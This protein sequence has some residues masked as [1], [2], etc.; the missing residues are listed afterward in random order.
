MPTNKIRRLIGHYELVGIEDAL[1]T[2]WTRDDDEHRKSIRELTNWF[3]Q[4]LLIAVLDEYTGGMIP[5]DYTV[6]EITT[7][8]RARDS[9]AAK[10]DD[11][12]EREIT[13]VVQW[14]QNNDVPV[15]NVIDDFVSYGTMY[16]YLKDVQGAV[17]PESQ[18]NQ[19]SPEERQAVVLK[20]VRNDLTKQPER[21]NSRLRTLRTHYQ[22]PKIKPDIHISVECNCP[23]CGHAQPI[24]DYIRYQGCTECGMHTRDKSTPDRANRDS[25]ADGNDPAAYDRH[26]E[27][28]KSRHDD[29]PDDTDTEVETENTSID[30]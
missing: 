30:F 6:E 29:V 17:S 13:D 20:G 18:P 7:R 8:L 21:I 14:L 22:L 2:N 1:I 28:S 24:A 19:R 5:T 15:D 4:K 12:P 11:I 16:T 25:L 9:D 10:Y 23:A 27:F 3:N 26:E